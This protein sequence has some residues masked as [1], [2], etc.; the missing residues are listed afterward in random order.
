MQGFFRK[1]LVAFT[2]LF[3]SSTI[4]ADLTVATWNI[5]R[6]GHGNQTSYKAL[7]H[8]AKHAD[9]IAVQEVMNEQGIERFVSA[10]R[11]ATGEKGW[12]VINSHLVGTRSYKEMYSFV[13]RD[14]AVAYEDGAVVYLDRGDRFIREPFSA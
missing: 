4:A 10:L 13:F 12:S 7:A 5:K 9:L 14:S 6:L 1:A 11:T 3:C 8:V 2:I